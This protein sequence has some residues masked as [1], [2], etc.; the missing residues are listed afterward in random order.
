MRDLSGLGKFGESSLKF[1]M[2][3]G[4]NRYR[5]CKY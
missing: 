4:L 2:F 5:S 1:R 3:G